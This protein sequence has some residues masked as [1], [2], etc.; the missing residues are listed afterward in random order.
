MWGAADDAASSKPKMPVEAVWPWGFFNAC[1]ARPV[2][3]A[4]NVSSSKAHKAAKAEWDKLW[5]KKG[6]A[7]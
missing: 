4:E 6:L 5:E 7:V 2:R 1:V 3:K